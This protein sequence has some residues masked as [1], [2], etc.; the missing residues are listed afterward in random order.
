MAPPGRLRM[1][2]TPPDEQPPAEDAPAE[3]HTRYENRC[4]EQQV[5]LT[6]QDI[7]SRNLYINRH[8]V[9][10]RH[11]RWW[12][13]TPLPA[14]PNW[15]D[16]RLDLTGAFLLNF[17]LPGCQL[18]YADLTSAQ[19]TE[20]ASFNGVQFTGTAEFGGA[21]F[22]GETDFDGARVTLA[23]EPK[24]VW[25]PGWTTRPAE[26]DNGED[27]AFRYLTKVEDGDPPDT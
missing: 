2:Y 5:R 13:R 4:Q 15:P 10:Q 17:S 16:I 7:L 11:R 24:S 25:P 26:P 6:A 20:G 19:F 21:Q 9:D 8:S 14:V 22:T 3:A 1:P 18:D 27:P 12:H 23:A